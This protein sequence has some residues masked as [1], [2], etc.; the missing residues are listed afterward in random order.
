MLQ[1]VFHILFSNIVSF[2]KVISDLWTLLFIVLAHITLF[3]MEIYLYVY[4]M[5]IYTYI[6]V[7]QI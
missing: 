6:C 4:N 7:G 1:Y 2:W 3:G 5:Y